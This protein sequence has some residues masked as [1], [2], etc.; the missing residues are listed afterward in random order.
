MPENVP[1][2]LI[3]LGASGRFV[4][5]PFPPVVGALTLNFD[6]SWKPGGSHFCSATKACTCLLCTSSEVRATALLVY[7]DSMYSWE[8]AELNGFMEMV[9]NYQVYR[10]GG[11]TSWSGSPLGTVDV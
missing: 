8:G 5:K 6:C 2:K 9:F 7:S 4:S 1:A 10:S 3:F 11:L